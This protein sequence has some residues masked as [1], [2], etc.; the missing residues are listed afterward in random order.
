MKSKTNVLPIPKPTNI[1]TL[2]YKFSII[3]KEEVVK[4][5]NYCIFDEYF[6]KC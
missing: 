2:Y 5:S 4:G 6:M 1:N 3:K